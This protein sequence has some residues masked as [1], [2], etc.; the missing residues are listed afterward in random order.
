[1]S[2]TYKYQIFSGYFCPLS[3]KHMNKLSFM[4]YYFFEFTWLK[5]VSAVELWI[6]LIYFPLCSIPS[7]WHTHKHATVKKCEHHPSTN[8]MNQ[9]NCK[10]CIILQVA[11]ICGVLIY[12]VELMLLTKALKL[13]L[14]RMWLFL[15]GDF[16]YLHWTLKRC[17]NFTQIAA[18]AGE[19][20]ETIRPF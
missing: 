11:F 19:E 10:W 18:P 17:F 13:V 4:L 16:A 20:T 2:K 3:T 12:L 7:W 14:V 8:T 1:M 6:I 15:W 5:T 9:T